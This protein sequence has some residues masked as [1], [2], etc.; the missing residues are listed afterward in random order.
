MCDRFVYEYN[1]W[2]KPFKNWLKKAWDYWDY[3]VFGYWL[4]GRE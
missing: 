3:C 4:E 1:V 2:F